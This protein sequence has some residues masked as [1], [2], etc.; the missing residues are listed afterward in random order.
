MLLNNTIG[1][2]KG[3]STERLGSFLAAL[4]AEVVDLV[5][6]NENDSIAINLS[7]PFDYIILE[8]TDICQIDTIRL[9][10][11]NMPQAKVI[12]VASAA[13]AT[14]IQL[15]CVQH[16]AVVNVA[17]TFDE[18]LKCIWQL[19]E[20]YFYVSPSLA[21]APVRSQRDGNNAFLMN[22]L[23]GREK[24]TLALVCEGYT[25][26]RIANQLFISTETVKNH[27]KHIIQKL[28]LNSNNELM[29]LAG[30]MRET[31]RQYF[32]KNDP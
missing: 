16:H 8:I 21:S 29:L 23:S 31:W 2:L 12:C 20:G 28:N 7:R 26:Q 30:Q 25:N 14:Q 4:Q 13:V 24:E 22:T 1:I 19:R 3:S 15:Q 32:Q 18:Y 17:A 27:K 6:N 9:F 10:I 5:L 11:K